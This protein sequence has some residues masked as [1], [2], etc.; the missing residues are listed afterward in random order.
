MYTSDLLYTY[1]ILYFLI[2]NLNILCFMI[3][4][5]I[6]S[7]KIKTLSQ[8]T[9]LNDWKINKVV[10]LA[11]LFTIAGIPP[12]IFFFFKITFIYYLINISLYLVILLYLIL[13]ISIY[14]Y[15]SNVRYLLSYSINTVTDFPASIL[16]NSYVYY[17]YSIFVGF[18]NIM[19]IFFLDDIII[20]VS[21]I[22]Q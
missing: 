3:S 8:L 9:F 11:I 15:I 21:Y 1:L 10:I 6:F 17:Y 18:L 14:F 2:Y 7:N 20:I 13:L 16:I 22:L 19:G 12:F 5:N 4:L